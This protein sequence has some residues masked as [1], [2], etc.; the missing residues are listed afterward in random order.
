MKKFKLGIFLDA[1][2]GGIDPKGRYTTFPNKC[3]HFANRKYHGN[4]WF[5][6]GVSNRIITHRIAAK[7]EK[8]GYYPIIVSHEYLDTPLTY[9]TNKANILSKSFDKSLFISNHSNAFNRLARGFEVF[10]SPG[11]TRADI[12]AEIYY[13]NMISSFGNEIIWRKESET[14]KSKEASYTVLTRTAMPAILTEHL[15]FDNIKDAD[16]L[17]SEEFIEKVSDVQVKSIEDYFKQ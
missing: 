15:F 13:D 5:Y 1:G 17:I 3:A 7:L 14:K 8:K 10:T 4:G 6:E 16:I 12:L 2:H 9:R 11:R